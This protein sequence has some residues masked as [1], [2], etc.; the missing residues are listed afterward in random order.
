MADAVRAEAAQAPAAGVVAA[1]QHERDRIHRERAWLTTSV[2]EEE[3]AWIVDRGEGGWKESGSSALEVD[4]DRGCSPG[5]KGEF[6]CLAALGPAE[7]NDRA[8]E[9]QII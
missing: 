5:L 7:A 9:V 8:L 3:P 6:E 1:G 4:V 2:R